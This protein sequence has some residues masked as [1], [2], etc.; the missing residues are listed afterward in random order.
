[1]REIA[2]VTEHDAIASPMQLPVR[3]IQPS[4][5]TIR[6]LDL[7][8]IPYNNRE[9]KG[10][11]LLQ[12]T[13]G[14]P[15]ETRRMATKPQIP[16]ASSFTWL[17]WDTVSVLFLVGL[18]IIHIPIQM[19]SDLSWDAPTSFRKPILFGI[20]TGLTLGSLLLLLNDLRPKPWDRYLRSWLCVSLVAEVLL[21]T[22]QAWRRVPS[23][24]NRATVVDTVIEVSML[25]F[26][27]FAV[28]WI[29]VLTLR[30]MQQ[31]AF[32]AVSPARALAQQAGMVF[33]TLSCFL[34]IGITVIGNYQLLNGGSTETLGGKGV[35]KFPHG[36]V[37]H[38][39]QTLV[40]WSWLCDRFHAAHG[41]MSVALLSG[42]HV[43]FV[44]YAVRQ[45]WMGRS[46]WD[47]DGTAWG[48]LGAASLLAMLA[49]AIALKRTR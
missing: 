17:R 26:I 19:A 34:G 13:L 6:R 32:G 27:L 11:T 49:V 14:N 31:N 18:G 25:A 41:K 45:T 33:L 44:M 9:S 37:L 22:V 12:P 21:I 3:A 40:A 7:F 35:L 28:V 38:A 1:M 36:A 8:L 43:A 42:A 2:N 23:H 15:T 20:S 4:D 39:I 10:P 16:N 5:L 47:G 46:R 48:L 30:S 24:F 29:F